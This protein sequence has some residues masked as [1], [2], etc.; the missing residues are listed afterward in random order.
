MQANNT[1]NLSWDPHPHAT[2]YKIEYSYNGSAFAPFS[3]GVTSSYNSFGGFSCGTAVRLR[4]S[5]QTPSGQTAASEVAFSANKCPTHAPENFTVSVQAAWANL[6][7]TAHPHAQSYII[8]YSYN[9]AP[10]QPFQIGV[11]SS[12]NGW[13]G[14]S[15]GSTITLRLSANTSFGRTAYSEVTF[16][17]HVCASSLEDTDQD[18]RTQ[19]FLPLVSR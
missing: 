17:G 11:T 13:M 8:E 12:Y 5:A 19:I 16:N 2:G 14:Y 10:F 6:S 7:W 3:I 18:A 4:L 15:C 9:G 1:A